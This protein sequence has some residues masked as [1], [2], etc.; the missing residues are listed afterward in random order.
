MH[1][2]GK[3]TLIRLLGIVLTLSV[4]NL[5]GTAWA[6]DASAEPELNPPQGSRQ[7]MIAD[8][9]L[10]RPFGLANTVVGIATWVLSLPFT[11]FSGSVGDAGEK[12][13]AEP[14]A[15]TFTRPLGYPAPVSRDR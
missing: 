15:H 14:A 10:Q 4:L 1:V 13:V 5:P 3:T 7:D 8:L 6:A 9:V 12:L 11:I 2:T